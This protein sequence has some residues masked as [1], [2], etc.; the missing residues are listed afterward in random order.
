MPN[1]CACSFWEITLNISLYGTGDRNIG[2]L[3]I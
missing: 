1:K 2:L 3:C